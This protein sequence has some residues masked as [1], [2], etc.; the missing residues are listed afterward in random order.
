MDIWGILLLLAAPAGLLFLYFRMSPLGRA[1]YWMRVRASLPGGQGRCHMCGNR[2][3]STRFPYCSQ[4]HA[5]EH[6]TITAW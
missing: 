6:Q 2:A 5:D 1:A 3:L 4:E